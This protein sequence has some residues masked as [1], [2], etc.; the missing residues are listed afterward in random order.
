MEPKQQKINEI[1][2]INGKKGSGKSYFVQHKIIPSLGAFI[3]LDKMEEYRG[4]MV[5]ENPGIMKTYIQRM[6]KAGK[7]YKCIFRWTNDDQIEQVWE[8]LCDGEKM[9]LENFTLVVEEVDLYCDSYGIQPELDYLIRYGRHDSVSLIWV[10]R[11]PFE[12]NRMLTRLTD[13]YVT[14]VQSEPRDINWLKDFNWSKD[15][16]TLARYEYGYANLSGD[17]RV[18]KKFNLI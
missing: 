12:I 8:M 6:I 1:I 16:T 17:E 3:I 10:S 18:L 15:P 4:G 2:G 7:M 9:L 14:F 13:V 5:F 11:S